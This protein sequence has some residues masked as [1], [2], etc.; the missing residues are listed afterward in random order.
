M[1]DDNTLPVDEM[2]PANLTFT[3]CEETTLTLKA[4]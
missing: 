2:S 4:I 1:S 3:V